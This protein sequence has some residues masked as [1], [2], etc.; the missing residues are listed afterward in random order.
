MDDVSEPEPGPA[1][2]P[3]LELAG[4]RVRRPD[5]V[6]LL[7]EVEL[8]VRPGEVIALLG[9][10]GAGKSTLLGCIEDPAALRERGFLVEHTR[11]ELRAQV[12][13]VPQRGALF[14]HLSVGDNLRLALRHAVEGPRPSGVPEGHDEAGDEAVAAWLGRMHLPQEWARQPHASTWLSGGEAQ[15]VAVARTLAGGRRILFLDEP[16]VGLD[17]YRVL[18]L[19]ALLRELIR[20][21]GAAAI[22]I[23]HDLAFA[24]AFADRFWFMDRG[25]RGVD[26]LELAELSP[27]VSRSAEQVWRIE[28]Q[29]GEAVLRRLEDDAPPAPGGAR[30][31]RWAAARD[32]MVQWV[33]PFAVPVE[34]L[35]HLPRSAAGVRRG[36]RDAAEVLPVVL[37]QTLLRPAPFFAIVS[38]LIGYSVLYI[39]H[40]AFADGDLA[41][42]DGFVFTLLGSRHIIALAPPLAG[43]LFCATS[44]NAITAWLGGISL[45]RQS[46]ALRG[47][48]VSP[49]R[50][51]WG[52]AWLG[53]SL[54]SFLLS[55]LF[56]VGMVAG[57]A[58]YIASTGVESTQAYALVTA[59]LL[60]PAPG[61]GRLL[62]RAGLLLAIYAVGISADAVAKG[63][64]DKHS[65][66]AVTESMVRS[67]MASTLWIV[68]LELL[69]LP[70]V[71]G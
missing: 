71:L 45:T 15:R 31:S 57:G 34:V 42:R 19:A 35:R 33:E 4:L 60:D 61:D 70:L 14:D 20:E 13:I 58:L 52:P 8:C 40:R 67:V 65:A 39:F 24:A 10:S 59:Q 11:R 23:T 2:E 44:G 69:T 54:S 21:R 62:A 29:L 50:Y 66:E 32:R 30:G 3:L 9:G 37:K 16:S 25:R 36:L 51:L 48:G 41:L 53:L 18:V 68:A 28:Q 27:E 47:L 63:A 55:S 17:P 22:V 43:I 49:R 1:P 5:G 12:G 38:T 56:V 26:E 46:E 7:T 6:E 64:R